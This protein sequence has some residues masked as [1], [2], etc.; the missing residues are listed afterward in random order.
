[1]AQLFLDDIKAR[2]NFPEVAMARLRELLYYTCVGGKCNRGA[3]V[4]SSVTHLCAK[5]GLELNE[6]KQQQALAC[7]WAIEALQACF[8]VADDI[9]DQSE[10]RRGQPCWYKKP[11][12]QYDAVNDSLILESFVFFLV[13]H[14]FG[15]NMAQYC[16]LNDLYR[17]VSL[18]TQ[19]GQMLDLCSQPQGRKDPE[20]LKEFTLENLTR[21]HTYK[22]AFYSFYL[23]I[24]AGFIICGEDNES[25][26]EVLKTISIELGCKFQIQDDYL[27][28]FAD[29]AILGKI[30]TDIK[31]HKHTWL[32][33]LALTLMNA[34]QRALLEAH[35]GKETKEDEV[36]IR[37]L[38]RDLNIPA[39]YLQQE[40]ESYRRITA[41]INSNAETVPPAIFTEVLDT[42]QLRPK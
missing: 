41:L 7:G 40:E 36:A 11:T 15:S 10:T 21:I 9:M 32:V 39:L 30:G 26:F 35:Y 20:L 4:L 23:P 6:E 37:Q 16:A 28:C 18:Q 8:L 1:M 31:D 24:A 33:S 19:L 14:F 25:V 17:E 27:D 13:K 12:V 3:L 29:P 2:Y 5:L 42:I 38:Y 22:T 34:E